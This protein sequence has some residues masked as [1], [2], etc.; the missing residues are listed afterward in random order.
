MPTDPIY[1]PQDRAPHRALV[2]AEEASFFAQRQ[3]AGGGEFEC[4]V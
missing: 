4:D 3:G 2:V 1:W